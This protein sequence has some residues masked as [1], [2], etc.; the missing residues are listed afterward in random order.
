LEFTPLRPIAS[1]VREKST[2][3]TAALRP[4]FA[5]GGKI[6]RQTV[7]QAWDMGLDLRPRLPT[8]RAAK[9]NSYR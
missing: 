7:V 1:S 8:E 4:P 3:K 2:S 9:S 5:F 6:A